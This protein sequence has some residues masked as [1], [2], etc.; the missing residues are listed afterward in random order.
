M[1]TIETEATKNIFIQVDTDGIISDSVIAKLTGATQN[2]L[3][4]C[5]FCDQGSMVLGS[6]IKSFVVEVPKGCDLRFTVV[7]LELFTTNLLY[8]AAVTFSVDNTIVYDIVT[9]PSRFNQTLSF[10]VEYSELYRYIGRDITFTMTISL[11]VPGMGDIVFIIDPVLR[12][13][14]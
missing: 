2:Y 4:N 7:P 5:V 10:N 12:I 13:K 9:E 14:Q 3:T 8:F 6:H 11:I 1:S